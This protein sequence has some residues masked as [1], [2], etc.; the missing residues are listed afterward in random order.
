MG[1]NL[2]DTSPVPFGTRASPVTN[3]GGSRH[4]P[5]SSRIPIEFT[6]IAPV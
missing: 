6:C 5:I 4:T 1:V 3:C 2:R